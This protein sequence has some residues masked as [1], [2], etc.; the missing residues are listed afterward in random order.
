[1]KKIITLLFCLLIMFTLVACNN[2]ENEVIEDT[3]VTLQGKT[4][5]TSALDDFFSKTFESPNFMAITTCYGQIITIET[6]EGT[7]ERLEEKPTNRTIYVFIKDGDYYTAIEETK[8][9]EVGK[10]YYDGNYCLFM[11]NVKDAKETI[12]GTFTCIVDKDNDASTGK[13]LVFEVENDAKVIRI[14]ANQ[15]D[16]VVE[17]FVYESITKQTNTYF[18]KTVTF[19]YG[20]ISVDV[21]NIDDWT[22]D[23]GS[24]TFRYGN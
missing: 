4:E 8:Y 19:V 24:I 17:K 21:P 5:C 13:T 15:V 1:M 23:S 10:I 18:A 16:G 12:D 2:E 14:T 11:Q 9:Y 7:T 3:K 20:K 6:V 22:M